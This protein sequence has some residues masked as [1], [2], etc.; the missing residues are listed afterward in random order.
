MVATSESLIS[1][2]AVATASLLRF[3]WLSACHQQAHNRPIW[4]YMQA[5]NKPKWAYLMA[6][7]KYELLI[8]KSHGLNKRREGADP[9]RP[10]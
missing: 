4:A 3:E 1:F 10:A 6:I 9:F 7:G 2:L 8:S 5:K